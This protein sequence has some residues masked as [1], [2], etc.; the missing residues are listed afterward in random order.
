MKNINDSFNIHHDVCKACLSSMQIHGFRPKNALL[1]SHFPRFF[2]DTFFYTIFQSSFYTFT[3]SKLNLTCNFETEG[4][5][6]KSSTTLG[7]KKWN[8][9]RGP[10]PSRNTGPSFDH[11]YKNTSGNYLFFEASWSGKGTPPLK[12]GSRIVLESPLVLSSQV[13]LRFAYHMY[14]QSIGALEVYIRKGKH[15]RKMWSAEGNKK[16]K[17]HTAEIELAINIEYKVNYLI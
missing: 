14:G 2:H 8:I 16:D 3:V 15:F 13:C 12:E 11:T 6:W 4:C 17:W 1:E 5:E 10:T 9:G 7:V